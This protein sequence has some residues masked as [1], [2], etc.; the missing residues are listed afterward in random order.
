MFKLGPVERSGVR[1]RITQKEKSS[2]RRLSISHH[3]NWTAAEFHSTQWVQDVFLIK[4][5]LTSLKTNSSST[6]YY[7]VICTWCLLD[8]NGT[9]M[10]GKCISNTAEHCINPGRSRRSVLTK[11]PVL[12][13]LKMLCLSFFVFF[14]V[15]LVTSSSQYKDRKLFFW[16]QRNSQIGLFT[17]FLFL[18]KFS[19]LIH[20]SCIWTFGM[21]L[22]PFSTVMF[23]CV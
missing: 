16:L 8:N 6:S 20:L 9:K 12:S 14:Y 13:L 10:L 1:A 7:S 5:V 3:F 11:Q 4:D 2:K 19:Y 15:V 23:V 17:R 18:C 22:L 21:N